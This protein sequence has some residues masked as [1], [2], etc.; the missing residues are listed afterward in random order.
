MPFQSSANLQSYGRAQLS[1]KLASKALGIHLINSKIS[2]RLVTTTTRLGLAQ[3][4][5]VSSSDATSQELAQQAFLNMQ[6]GVKAAA[7]AR[8]I[9]LER[10]AAQAKPASK[11]AALPPEINSARIYARP[12]SAPLLAAIALEQ[13]NLK[14]QQQLKAVA[15]ASDLSAERSSAQSE[16]AFA[17]TVP[18][19]VIAVNRTQLQILTA[20]NFLGQNTPAIAALEAQYAE[21]WAQDVAA[22]QAYRAAAAARDVAAEFNAGRAEQA[23]V[24]KQDASKLFEQHAGMN[25]IGVPH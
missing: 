3:R 9:S 19:P 1:K 10:S 5:G 18:P 24:A 8:D 12:G 17:M 25:I 11:F 23:F 13:S 2:Q 7:M 14:T 15:M 4:L 20:T 21:M 22:Q 6:K 16:Q